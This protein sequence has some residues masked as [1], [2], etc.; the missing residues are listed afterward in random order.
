MADTIKLA[1]F[2]H[3]RRPVHQP[4]G[5]VVIRSLEQLRKLRDN[6]RNEAPES[7]GF[8]EEVTFALARVTFIENSVVVKE[9]EALSEHAALA[10]ALQA[11]GVK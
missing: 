2:P 7:R 6:W 10:N 8:R 9:V 1:E 5:P 3:R 4:L 11:L